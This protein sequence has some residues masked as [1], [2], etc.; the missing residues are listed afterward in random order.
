MLLSV[1]VTVGELTVMYNFM[2]TVACRWEGGQS[3]CKST[4]LPLGHIVFSGWKG[5]FFLM[6][7]VVWMLHVGRARHPGQVV[8]G[9]SADFLPVEFVNVGLAYSL[10]T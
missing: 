4:F 8:C 2:G 3:H 5:T 1:V 7:L 10:G 6:D 9:A